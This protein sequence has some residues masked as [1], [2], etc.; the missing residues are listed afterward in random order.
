MTMCCRCACTKD[1]YEI[2]CAIL[3]TKT[4]LRCKTKQHEYRCT[5]NQLHD[6][7]Q[8]QLRFFLAAPCS[9][10]GLCLLCDAF[11]LS[12]STQR[13]FLEVKKGPRIPT[14][15]PGCSHSLLPGHSRKSTGSTATGLKRGG[16]VGRY[17]HSHA[18]CMAEATNEQ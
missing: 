5:S 15:A 4:K 9:F 17:L 3:C 16:G 14:L 6:K 18:L 12:V 1:G 8:S 2:P 11:W 13:R 10:M 7:N